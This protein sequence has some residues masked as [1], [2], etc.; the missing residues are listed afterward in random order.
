MGSRYLFIVLYVFL[1]HHLSRGDYRRADGA[2]RGSG[3]HHAVARRQPGR[4]WYRAGAPAADVRPARRGR[5]RS[6]TFDLIP[7]RSSRMV[8]R[9]ARSEE[10]QTTRLPC[11]ARLRPT[12]P[13]APSDLAAMGVEGADDWPQACKHLLGALSMHEQVLA[14]LLARVAVLEERLG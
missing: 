14:G 2:P 8:G 6:T 11:R 7:A 5:A 13:G 9:D 4:A 12:S 1:E 3:V 10:A